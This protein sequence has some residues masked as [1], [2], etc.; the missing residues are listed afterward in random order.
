MH[1]GRS[2]STGIGYGS[3]RCSKRLVTQIRNV[4]A[5]LGPSQNAYAMLFVC[6]FVHISWLVRVYVVSDSFAIYKCHMK[7]LFSCLH[8]TGRYSWFSPGT[9]MT[10]LCAG[11]YVPN[12]FEFISLKTGKPLSMRWSIGSAHQFDTQASITPR[13]CAK[14]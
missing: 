13:I 8:Q 10:R 12:F 5:I 7:S 14:A 3:P 4:H 9:L 11:S 6:F 2:I 1:T